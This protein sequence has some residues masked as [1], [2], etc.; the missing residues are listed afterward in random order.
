VNRKLLDMLAHGIYQVW[1]KWYKILNKSEA[2]TIVY[3]SKRKKI[4][5]YRNPLTMK[6]NIHTI[7][8]TYLVLCIIAF[9]VFIVEHNFKY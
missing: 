2:E 4:R 8:I 9:L 5:K 7:F 1:D 3:E 6:S